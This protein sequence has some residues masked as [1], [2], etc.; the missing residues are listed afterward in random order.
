MLTIGVD[1]GGTFTD[2]VIFDEVT[3]SLST[4][5][6]PS[7]PK[8][9]AQAV[10]TGIGFAL[11]HGIDPDQV[12][13][14]LHGSTITTNALLQRRGAKTGLFLTKGLKG[15][16]QVQS[17]MTSG[18]AYSTTKQRPPALIDELDVFEIPERIDREGKTVL[19]L[20]E[21]AVLR[22][23]EEINARGIESLAVCYVF[24]YANKKHEQRTQ[25]L[26]SRAAPKCRVFCS[27]DILPRIREWS[28][29]STTILD[30]YLEPV[31]V[32]Y[33]ANLA[34]GLKSFG[35]ATSKTFLMAS[36]GGVMPFGALALGGKAVH[37]LLSGPAAAVQAA[38]RLAEFRG[39]DNLVTM[40]IGGTSCDVAFVRAGA[41]LEVTSGTVAGYEVFVPMLD[42]ATIG[43]GGGTITRADAD[44]R[45]Q[46]GPESAGADPGPAA[47]GRGGQEATITDAD[48][49]LGYLNPAYFLGGALALDSDKATAAITRNI[50]VPLGLGVEE[51]AFSAVRINDVH[52]A[53]AVRAVAAK[54]GVSLAECHLVACGG[55]GPMHA[56]A[57]AEELGIPEVLVPRA[58]GV[59]AALGLLCTDVAEDHVQTDIGLLEDLDPEAIASQFNI[60][61]R[62]AIGEY[63]VQG[64]RE[65]EVSFIREVDARYPGQGF[66][67]RV[68]VND[69]HDLAVTKQIARKFHTQHREIYGHSSDE[70][71]VE[72]VSYRIRA[73]I[74][75]PQYQP[76]STMTQTASER[77]TISQ[78]LVYFD[79]ASGFI[80]TPIYRRAGLGQS[81][82][83]EGPAVIEQEDTTT[84]IPPGWVASLD[85]FG[86]LVMKKK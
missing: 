41:A 44:G 83:I 57:I 39:V 20:D 24:S 8:D 10:L 43:A 42:I 79:P 81:D 45:L 58:P 22:A 71:S 14:F 61:E 86:T 18:P 28:R 59:F 36:N 46:V 7:T 78:R 85:E 16:F 40:D 70:E 69:P 4:R 23:A 60:L 77:A 31:L 26:L 73:V 1:V 75:M 53:E 66:E 65:D 72:I 63:A 54:A 30:A 13:S 3:N 2:I 56:A 21:D 62:K 17:Q 84:V 38:K 51:A 29:M 47:Y 33:V 12:N 50:A 5:K 52:M 11:G 34:T 32:D 9:P 67:I 35:V 15:I 64:F 49:V 37:T 6:V 55:A 48:I 80:Q 68:V 19:E 82:L 76:S 25:E 74:A 27:S